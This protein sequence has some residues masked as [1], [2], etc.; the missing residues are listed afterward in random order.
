MNHT[1]KLA[2]LPSLNKTYPIPE[3]Q[4]PTVLQNYKVISHVGKGGFS[5]VSAAVNKQNHHK[6]AIKT[7][8]RIDQMQD[9]KLKSI[10]SEVQNLYNLSHENIIQ[11]KHAV[12]DGR[13][14]Q[15]VMENGG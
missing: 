1:Q 2:P 8:S 14:I 6:Y 11:L 13:K 3:L 12:K 7:Y 9:F 4:S 15:L 5:V 10:Q